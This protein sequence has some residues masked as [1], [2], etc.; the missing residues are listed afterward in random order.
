[1]TD[2]TPIGR[3]P[4]GEIDALIDEFGSDEWLPDAL[5][6][7]FYL[8]VFA[9]VVAILAWVAHGYFLIVLGAETPEFILVLMCVW[10]AVIAYSATEMRRLFRLRM[11]EA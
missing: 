7:P 8:A 1:M 2:F 5:K 10:L 11:R 3:I 9:S 4:N 6:G